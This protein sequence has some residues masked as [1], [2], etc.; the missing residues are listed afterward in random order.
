MITGNDESARNER[1][2]EILGAYYE[3]AA[4]GREPDRADWLARH[5]EFA[6]ELGEF[7]DEQ[8]RL[9]RLAA[10]LREAIAD[11]DATSTAAPRRDH[12]ATDPGEDGDDRDV[13]SLPGEAVRYFGDY[14]LRASGPRR[15]GRRLSRPGS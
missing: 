2:C 4:T 5:P 13:P 12:A 7:F 3:A 15:H 8:D 6:A 1:L 10:P 14:E 11:P 9:G